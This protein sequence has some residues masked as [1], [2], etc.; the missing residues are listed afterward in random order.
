MTKKCYIA[1][2][3][4]SCK[5]LKKFSSANPS[6]DVRFV[7]IDTN[8]ENGKLFDKEDTR[9]LFSDYPYKSGYMR[10]FGKDMFKMRLYSGEFPDYLDE[11]YNT[12]E[13]D[14]CF[15]TTSFGGFGSAVVF[16]LADYMCAKISR[17]S[18]KKAKINIR[19]I[20]FSKKQFDMIF[21]DKELH[22]IAH[23]LNEYEFVNEAKKRMAISSQ[24][25]SKNSVFLLY[26]P[27][28]TKDTLH[29][30]LGKSI[31]DLE[32]DNIIECYSNI[33]KIR[34]K[35]VFISFSSI[36]QEK[37]EA[38]VDVLDAKDISAW[39]SS[40]DMKSGDFPCQIVQAIKGA[41]VFVVLISKN[42]LQSR[43]VKSEVNIAFD[44]RDK[45][46]LIPL[47]IDESTLDESFA[48][49]LNTSQHFKA[50][51][52][53]WEGKIKKLCDEIQEKITLLQ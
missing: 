31:E 48:Y 18:S 46:I 40:R 53:P 19:T 24:F 6:N 29:L 17:I 1:I 35:D 50:E 34:A 41:K 7:Y 20:A 27:Y 38:L 11:F 16:E 42:S 9:I 4:I 39:I 14:L 5:V 43:H 13:I 28:L 49:Y 12:D 33:P 45:N 2:G 3:S 23:S 15:I 32:H 8:H 51:T 36:D 47:F 21:D 30:A 26:S 25:F 37:A 44:Q 22:E 52:P 10:S